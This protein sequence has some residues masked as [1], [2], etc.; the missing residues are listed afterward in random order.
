M[1]VGL[2]SWHS[3]RKMWE[4]R[5]SLSTRQLPQPLERSEN[6][7]RA[8][9]ATAT[10]DHAVR[11]QGPA[12]RRC[13]LTQPGLTRPTSRYVSRSGASNSCRLCLPSWRHFRIPGKYLCDHLGLGPSAFGAWGTFLSLT[14]AGLIISGQGTWE[15]A[16]ENLGTVVHSLVVL[17][18]E[19]AW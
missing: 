15:S 8:T 10:S 19:F 3:V 11:A 18:L 5:G 16:I 12:L 17:E 9:G 1:H 2:G 4:G 14:L 13:S 6:E 7:F